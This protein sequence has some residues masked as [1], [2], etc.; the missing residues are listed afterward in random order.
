MPGRVLVSRRQRF[1]HAEQWRVVWLWG[2]VRRRA[3]AVSA[4]AGV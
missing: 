1:T 3:V 4:G 2:D